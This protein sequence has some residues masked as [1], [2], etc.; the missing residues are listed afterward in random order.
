MKPPSIG[1]YPNY[2]TEK[3]KIVWDEMIRKRKKDIRSESD[4]KRQWAIA[5]VLYKRSCHKSRIMPF[6]S[7]PA[8]GEKGL[9]L[10]KDSLVEMIASSNRKANH[11]VENFFRDLEDH[12]RKLTSQ[13]FNSVKYDNGLYTILLHRKIFLSKDVPPSWLFAYLV[14]KHHFLR[15]D[16]S[17]VKP[18]DTV[19]DIVV[20]DDTK[21]KYQVFVYN[22]IR[23]SRN[24][25]IILS[26]A[27]ESSNSG[28]IEKSLSRFFRSLI[29]KGKLPK[30]REL[31]N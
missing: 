23:L 16:R 1:I 12:A 27:D 21:N 20:K 24:Q 26:G 31:K 5:L 30:R 10:D 6:T 15:S 19:S 11:E 25:A 7:H 9:Q 4:I 17:V 28:Q 3:G 8:S 29:K 13:V 18:V 22:R 2:I 14:G